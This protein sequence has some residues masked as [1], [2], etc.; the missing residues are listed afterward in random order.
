MNFTKWFRT[1]LLKENSGFEAF[2]FISKNFMVVKNI[3]IIFSLVASVESLS[4][5]ENRTMAECAKFCRS[6]AFVDL[7]LPCHSAFVVPEIFL[8]GTS[9]VENIFSWVF[10]GPKIFSRGWVF[11]LWP[12]NFFS[13]VFCGFK[14]LWL[15]ID[16]SKKQK[17]T[18]DWG[19]LTESFN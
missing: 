11:T 5:E 4:E 10:R 14:T 13:W 16:F 6:H 7:V 15:S 12:Q 8:V 19:I 18:D 3:I 17:E 2:F 9:W 1:A